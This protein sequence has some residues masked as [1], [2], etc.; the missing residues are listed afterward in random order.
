VVATRGSYRSSAL[1][2][3][4]RGSPSLAPTA[5]QAVAGFHRRAGC[6]RFFQLAA[7]KNLDSRR[8][9]SMRARILGRR[10]SGSMRS[11][12]HGGQRMV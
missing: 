12:P 11:A 1:A 3:E 10:R 6:E 9:S 7:R 5:G 8:S 4:R 2:V